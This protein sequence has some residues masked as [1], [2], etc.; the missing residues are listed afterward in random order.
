MAEKIK[1]LI[2]DDDEVDRATVKRSLRSADFE[3]ETF[4]ADSASAGLKLIKEQT[5]DCLLIDFKL[6]DMDGLE[7][8]KEIRKINKIV[9]VL[10]VTSYGDERVAAEAIKMG[11]SDY[12]SKSLITPE[13]VSHSLRTAIRLARIEQEKSAAEESLKDTQNQLQTII[14]NTPIVLW[15]IDNN[16]I[17]NF[18]AGKGLEFVGLK[19]NAAIGKSIYDVF[20]DW[21]ELINNLH[22]AM[23]GEIKK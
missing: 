15:G 1:I 2:I 23:R 17:F 11:A 5:F 19:G 12:I 13:S 3:A 10:L 21:P 22:R 8:L 20:K 7:L 14:Q 16:G 9:P 6:P 18:S 4:M